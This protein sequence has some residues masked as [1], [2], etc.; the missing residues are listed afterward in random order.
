MYLSITVHFA[1]KFSAVFIVRHCTSLKLKL[2]C[3]LC[4]KDVVVN[5]QNFAIEL[6][7]AMWGVQ[8]YC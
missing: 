3:L 6:Y 8:L 2:L 5:L 4:Y 1:L 7:L